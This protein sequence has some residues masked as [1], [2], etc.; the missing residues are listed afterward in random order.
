[1]SIRIRSG[2]CSRASV[3]P[4]S[5]LVAAT[6]VWSA[7]SSRNVDSFMF[8]ALSSTIRMVAMSGDHRAAGHRAPD[9]GHEAL[10]VEAGLVHDRR[11]EAIQARAVGLRDL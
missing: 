4:V 1:M 11:D 2:C 10:S 5:A 8:V 3:N 6:T 7:D 9:L